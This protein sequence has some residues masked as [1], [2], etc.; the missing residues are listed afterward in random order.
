MWGVS[1]SG[2]VD[3]HEP[4]KPV[5]E[6]AHGLLEN[7]IR[8]LGLSPEGT[9]DMIAALAWKMRLRLGLKPDRAD[10][11]KKLATDYASAVAVLLL[12]YSRN[13]THLYYGEI[14]GWCFKPLEEFL[15]KSNYGLV[16][17]EHRVLQN[18]ESA[19]R[20]CV[21][22]A[23]DERHYYR[24]EYLGSG[25]APIKTIEIRHTDIDGSI[26]NVDLHEPAKP[27]DERAHG[28]LENRIRDLGLSPEGTE[29]MIAALAWKMRLR[30][31]L[32]PDRADGVKKLATDYASAVA[33]LLLSYSRNIT[34][35]YYGEIAGWCFKPLEEFL[36]KSNYGLVSQE[37]RVLQ[38]LESAQRL[39]VS[40]ADDERHYY[41]TEYL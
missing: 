2:N 8:D 30:L 6:R 15:Y 33:V 10:G 17:Q 1:E 40:E 27:V 16:S 14:A 9:E 38:N 32:K 5:D 18:L 39:C 36:Y 7:R 21:S 35:L 34:H 19:Q 26:G 13:I 41:R 11:V 23:D 25:S 28:L 4:A 20:L 37:H 12:S 22:E 3:L 29:D 24:T 31:G